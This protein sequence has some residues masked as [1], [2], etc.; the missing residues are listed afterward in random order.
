MNLPAI[1]TK[2]RLSVTQHYVNKSGLAKAFKLLSHETAFP[3]CPIFEVCL[4]GDKTSTS[5][6][7]HFLMKWKLASGKEEK[8]KY[9]GE[10][11]AR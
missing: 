4:Q 5:S 11:K 10:K 8:K 1:N 9:W 2:Q 7:I 3:D 6:V